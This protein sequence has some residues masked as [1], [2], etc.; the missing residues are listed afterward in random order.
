MQLQELR[1]DAVDQLLY[2]RDAHGPYISL[3]NYLSRV[4]P[5]PADVRLLVKAG[6]F[7]NVACGRT[8]PEC[9]WVLAR[10]ERARDRSPQISLLED[11]APPPLPNAP[12]YDEHTM[13]RHEAE[14]IGFLVS[15]HP[16]TLYREQ[17]KNLRHV[18][19][20][21]LARYVGRS[22]TTIGWLVTAKMTSTKNEEPMQFVSFED[23]TALYETTFFPKAYQR[24]CALLTRGRPFILRGRVEEDF[25]AV[26]LNVTHVALL[27]ERGRPRSAPPVTAAQRASA[28]R[29]HFYPT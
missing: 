19:G 15:R 12:Q 23:T 21:D 1:R 14:V 22:V 7:D 28:A 6:C 17:L 8:R 25:G 16:L 27:D 5:D 11:P 3:E 4:D 13:L 18:Q 24:F 20:K 2:E 9:M 10:W 29:F 26:M